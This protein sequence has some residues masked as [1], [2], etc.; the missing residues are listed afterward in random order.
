MSKYKALAVTTINR[1]IGDFLA[2]EQVMAKEFTVGGVT[3][4][5]IMPGGQTPEAIDGWLTSPDRAPAFMVYG[6]E[7]D[8]HDND[9]VYKCEK[10]SYTIFAPTVSKVL[11]IMAAIKDL[12]GRQDWSADDVNM[13]ADQEFG[14]DDV[15]D[16]DTGETTR[17]G[18]KPFHIFYMEH[19][20]VAGATPLEG[21]GGRYAAI[22]N[23]HYHYTYELNQGDPATGKGRG[24]RV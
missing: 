23:I 14:Y 12:T 13:W 10:I 21:E 3:Q 22:I 4:P 19:E 18:R 1:W 20:Q 9:I 6:M 5:S 8:Q 15:V 2:D 16:G 11:E 7:L 17:W 24:M